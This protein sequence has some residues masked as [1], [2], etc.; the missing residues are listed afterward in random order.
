M[1]YGRK[2]AWIRISHRRG[3]EGLARQSRNQ[4]GKQE[5]TTENAEFAEVFLFQSLFSLS[6]LAL[7]NI[8]IVVA[9]CLNR[10]VIPRG[11]RLRG[12]FCSW[13]IK[14]AQAAT[15]LNDSSTRYKVF[16]CRA[17]LPNSSAAGF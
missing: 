11:W 9:L 17:E 2:P 15:I 6:P 4:I 8:A 3:A 12:E 5:F 10:V 1:Q 16:P 13:P 14:F 7:W